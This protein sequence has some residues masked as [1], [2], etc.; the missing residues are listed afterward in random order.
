[1]EAKTTYIYT[2]EAHE[3]PRKTIPS[4]NTSF[5]FG[6]SGSLIFYLLCCPSA[7]AAKL[8]KKKTKKYICTFSLWSLCWKLN[9]INFRSRNSNR[10]QTI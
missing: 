10:K 9:T 2:L 8:K 4:R 7:I 1:M 3:I 6:F 5:S